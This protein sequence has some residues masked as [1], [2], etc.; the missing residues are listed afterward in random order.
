M[1]TSKEMH[2]FTY[3]IGE[4]D[5]TY[6]ELALKVGLSD[7]A[8]LVLY[9][10]CDMG[11]ECSLQTICSF[12]GLAKQ[13]VNSALRKLEKEEVVILK[14]HNGRNKNVELTDKGMKLA[15]NTV[16]KIMKIENEIMESWTKEEVQQYLSLTERYLNMLK[17]KLEEM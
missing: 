1:H 11:G 13:T 14:Q 7:S 5:N 15:E 4:T 10:L 12:S 16:A 6:H 2:R 8:M 17:E 9:T 3:L